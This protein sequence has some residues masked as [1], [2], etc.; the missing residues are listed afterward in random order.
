MR[1]S[2][3]TVYSTKIDTRYKT[4]GTM[5][6]TFIWRAEYK[7]RLS[8]VIRVLTTDVICSTWTQGPSSVWA[9]AEWVDTDR[10]P[11]CGRW[12]VC[13][14]G[15][16]LPSP[17]YVQSTGQRRYTLSW[18][19]LVLGTLPASTRPL[20]RVLCAVRPDE[21]LANLRREWPGDRLTRLRFLVLFLSPSRQMLE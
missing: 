18:R 17:L 20:L 1:R 3:R 2:T 9:G 7:G 4:H 16:I 21:R 8:S 15:H 14:C 6:Y 11:Q 19:I 12:L 13:S 10:R 5:A